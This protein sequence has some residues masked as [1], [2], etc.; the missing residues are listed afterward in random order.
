MT[1]PAWMGIGDRRYVI[2]VILLLFFLWSAVFESK[3][4]GL[5]IVMGCKAD[6]DSFLGVGGQTID[7]IF[8]YLPSSSRLGMAR[9]TLEWRHIAPTAPDTLCRL[10][11]HPL[12]ISE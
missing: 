12:S 6:G 1:N 4:V 10:F 11:A 3:S 8:K 9:R 2:I 7:D 5:V